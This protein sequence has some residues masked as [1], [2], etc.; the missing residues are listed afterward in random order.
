MSDTTDNLLRQA[1]E[2]RRENRLTDAMRDLQDAVALLREEDVPL[3]LA[4]ALRDLGE[5][6][7]R[8]DGEA[9]RQ[10]YE[11]S[12]AILRELNVPLILAHA[13]RHLGDVHYD[14]GH[15]ALAEPYYREALT[16]YRGHDE[17]RPLDLANAIRSLAV[18]EGEAEEREEATR[19]WQEAY[20]LYLSLDVPSGVAESA[21]RLALLAHKGGDA[22][23]TRSWLTE[24]GTAARASEDPEALQFVSGIRA[25]IGE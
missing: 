16:L 17:R 2:A 14:A 20:D 13:V 7:R 9:A 8:L 15:A 12:V 25:L 3:E 19:L 21:A 22:P 5:L 23:R 10:H 24:A 11:E 18:L 4:K 1:L 6:E